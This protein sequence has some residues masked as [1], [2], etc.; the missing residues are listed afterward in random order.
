[1]YKIICGI[2]I[3]SIFI[4][5]CATVPHEQTQ[6]GILDSYISKPFHSVIRSN[7]PP[8]RVYSD[9]NGGV[10]FS[11]EYDYTTTSPGISYSSQTGSFSA[12]NYG[13]NEVQ[14]KFSTQGTRFSIPPREQSHIEFFQFFINEDG[15]VYHHRTNAKSA[16]E[17]D[18]EHTNKW[19]L[20]L[21][22]SFLASA[23]LLL[24]LS[25]SQN[26]YD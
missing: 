17:E 25:Y 6:Q 3:G 8:T 16:A 26:H 10:I 11:Y 18:A 22:L 14:G 21:G 23:L 12:T 5:S 1:M 4:A 24:S 7:G 13:W 15:F 19:G 20:Y 2:L 9:G